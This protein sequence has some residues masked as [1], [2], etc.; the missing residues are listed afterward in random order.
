MLNVIVSC[1]HKQGV[2]ALK[3]KCTVV[4]YSNHFF[5]K[6]KISSKDF[7]KNETQACPRWHLIA[8]KLFICK[9]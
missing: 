7:D 2:V 3:Q 5:K 8:E 1:L 4:G 9:R 6:R